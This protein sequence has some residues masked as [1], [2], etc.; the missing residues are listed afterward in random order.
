M[1]RIKSVAVTIPCVTGPYTPVSCKLTLV[2]SRIRTSASA[3]APYA[4]TGPADPRF[5]SG[6]GGLPSIITSTGRQDAGM[7]ELDF[8]DDRYL[9]FEGAGAISTW[10]LQLPAG[11]HQ[12]DYRTIADVVLQVRYTARDGGE[13]LQAAALGQLADALKQMEIQDG[14]RGLYRMFSAKH[15]FPDEWY[16]FLHP[17]DGAAAQPVLELRLP[18][19]RFGFA[20]ADRPVKV[21]RAAVF[22]QLAPGVAY[23][24][25]DR[26]TLSLVPPGRTATAVALAGVGT[27]LGG[28]PAGAVSYGGGVPVALDETA[29]AWTVQPTVISAV[30]ARVV[31]GQARLDPDKIA[32]LGILCQLTY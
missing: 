3:A 29:A 13:L 6:A 16:Q 32:D 31:G 9:P 15:D 7:F 20:L 11:F 10:R 18:R 23:N 19:D 8:R 12:F 21:Q 27:A 14:K 25:A 2:N 24:E 28:L 5:V 30:L 4:W 26:T 17:P 22:V 1:R